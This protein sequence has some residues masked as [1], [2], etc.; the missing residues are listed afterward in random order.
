MRIIKEKKNK[1]KSRCK[2]FLFIILTKLVY[3][4]VFKKIKKE[5]FIF[6]INAFFE[7]FFFLTNYISLVSCRKALTRTFFEIGF[8]WDCNHDFIK[9]SVYSSDILKSPLSPN[10]VILPCIYPVVG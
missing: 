1:T 10:Y 7:V 2:F 5:L 9:I 6:E 3:K 8:F 4:I